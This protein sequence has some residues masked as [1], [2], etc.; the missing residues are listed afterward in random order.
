MRR[1]YGVLAVALAVALDDRAGG[2]GS[3]AVR[4]GISILCG[5]TCVPPWSDGRHDSTLGHWLRIGISPVGFGSRFA[6]CLVASG[7]AC[8]SAPGVQD[9]WRE[10]KAGSRPAAD[11]RRAELVRVLVDPV[12]IDTSRRCATSFAS[13]H[14]V[15]PALWA[16]IP[17]FPR[18]SMTRSTMASPRRSTRWSAISSI[19]LRSRWSACGAAIPRTVNHGG[20]RLNRTVGRVRTSGRLLASQNVPEVGRGERASPNC[21]GCCPGRFGRDHRGDGRRSEDRATLDQRADPDCPP[22][23]ERGETGRRGRGLSVAGSDRR[24]ASP[25][26]KQIR[27]RRAIRPPRRRAGGSLA[28]TVSSRRARDRHPGVRGACSCTSRTRI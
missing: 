12:A 11:P 6:G 5:H 21:D 23:L 16:A 15:P 14:A 25:D 9:V 7:R 4:G 22:P 13:S 27:A 2:L 19:S 24:G 28:D 20:G 17:P 1:P 10:A 26:S 8:G 3:G 18:A